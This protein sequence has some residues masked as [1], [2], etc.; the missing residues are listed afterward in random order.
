MRLDVEVDGRPRDVALE[1]RGGQLVVRLDGVETLVDALGLPGGRWS[2]RF[3]GSAR[4]WDV[5]VVAAGADAFEVL[6]GGHRVPVRVRTG[7]AR[8]S[9]TAAG[10][11]TGRVASPMPGK[12]VKLLVDIGQ[13][14]DARQG[15]IVVEAMKME[16]ELRAARAGVVRDILVEEGASVEAGAPLVVIE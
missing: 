6:V 8:T 7:V 1:R 12:V 13:A 4:Q 14:V 10:D 11:G 3:P 9:R 5:V 16:N 15:V 2:I